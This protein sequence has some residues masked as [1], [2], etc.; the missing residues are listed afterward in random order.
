MDAARQIE[1]AVTTE[2]IAG[3]LNEFSSSAPM[4]PQVAQL[5][6]T[7]IAKDHIKEGKDSKDGKDNK[8]RKD[9]IEII[10]KDYAKEGKDNK[11]GKDQKEHKDGK[12][13][14]ESKEQ[15][16]NK[17]TTDNAAAQAQKRVMDKQNKDMKD[18][19]DLAPSEYGS[20]PPGKGPY[21]EGPYGYLRAQPGADAPT[22]ST[23]ADLASDSDP[24]SGQTEQ[25]KAVPDS[26]EPTRPTGFSRPTSL[27]LQEPVL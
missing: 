16:E 11:D 22:D 9:S 19:K 8:E 21:P 12:D 1:P 10:S 2:E 24:A 3:L 25:T 18:A 7:E 14:K 27:L 13:Q 5:K 15:K 17:E 6:I 26:Q 23:D 20:G 4:T